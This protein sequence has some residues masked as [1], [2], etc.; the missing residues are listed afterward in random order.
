M[1]PKASA[2]A[3]SPKSSKR[4]ASPRAARPPSPKGDA[5]KKGAKGGPNSWPTCEFCQQKFS[6]SSLAIHQQKCRARPENAEEAASIAELAKLEGP[7]PLNPNADWEPCPNCGELYGEFALGPHVAR[8]KR[9]LPFGKKK[10]GKQYGTGRPPPGESKPAAEAFDDFGSGLT[11][12]EL[13]QLR[14]IFDKHD[15]DGNELLDETE[16]GA[17]LRECFPERA[18]DADKL[19]A[20]FKVA[21]LDGDGTVSFPEFA[22]YYAVLREMRP[23]AGLSPSEIEWLRLIFDRFDGDKDGEVSTQQPVV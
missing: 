2:R 20:E 9:L 14:A 6:P 3:P 1:A 15:T 5:P 18:G 4:A 7:R 22:R 11:K 17:L 19:L 10:D 23:G 13:E 8:C 21:D 12:A 16:L